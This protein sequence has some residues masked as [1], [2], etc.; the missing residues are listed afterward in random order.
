MQTT[1]AIEET[2]PIPVKPCRK[3]DKME[4]KKKLFNIYSLLRKKEES[5]EP[6]KERK[7]F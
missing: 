6:I 5:L 7:S 4:Q 3:Y 2:K 1:R